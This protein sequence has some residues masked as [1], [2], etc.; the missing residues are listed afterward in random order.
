MFTIFGKWWF[1]WWFFKDKKITCHLSPQW[2]FSVQKVKLKSSATSTRLNLVCIAIIQHRK[3]K[4]KRRNEHPTENNMWI[5]QSSIT[6]HTIHHWIMTGGQSL[7]YKWWIASRVDV[8]NRLQLMLMC[9]TTKVHILQSSASCKGVHL[10]SANARFAHDYGHNNGETRRIKWHQDKG[11]HI[12]FCFLFSSSHYWCVSADIQYEEIQCL[13]ET[14]YAF[15]T[16]GFQTS[17]AS[18]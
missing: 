8:Q 1:F 11:S 6:I 17:T 3:R 18:P 7:M 9:Q 4:K 16:G 13:S 2:D 10:P 12:T 15:W 5:V 14:I